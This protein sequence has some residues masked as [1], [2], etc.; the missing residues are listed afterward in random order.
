MGEH[1]QVGQVAPEEECTVLVPLCVQ[2]PRVAVHGPAQD[3]TVGHVVEVARHSQWEHVLHG[4]LT[5]PHVPPS[6]HED[7]RGHVKTG[8]MKLVVGGGQLDEL[9]IGGLAVDVWMHPQLEHVLQRG[10]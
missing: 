6:E 3:V 9:V 4:G 2:P 1:V 10:V 5:I 7:P 8:Q